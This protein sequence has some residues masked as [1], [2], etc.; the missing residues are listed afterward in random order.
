M[1][2]R[3]LLLAD[4]LDRIKA[5]GIEFVDV[6]AAHGDPAAI[7]PSDLKAEM[8]GR[9]LRASSITA[10]SISGDAM[11]QRITYAAEL[12]ARTVISAAP[13][14]DYDRREA[15]DDVRAYGRA[16]QEVGVT[17][18]LAHKAETWMDTAEEVAS[19]LDDVGHPRVQ[20]SIDP[21]QAAREGIT[22][23]SLADAA[24]AR[25]GHVY[26][27]QVSS[28]GADALAP[29]FDLLEERNYYG[30]FTF[31]GRGMESLSAEDAQASLGAAREHVLRVSKPG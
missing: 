31:S 18:C 24:G 25:L 13:M 16:A 29:M 8:D 14:R 17:F 15:A 20:L 22:F 4:A 1:L 27:D 30:M 11:L 23:E 10:Y 28:D 19:F 12:G 6:W 26:L 21:P 3:T 7:S 2:F 5:V 9:G